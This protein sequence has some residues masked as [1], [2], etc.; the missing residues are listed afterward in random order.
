MSQTSEQERHPE[1]TTSFPLVPE[2]HGTGPWALREPPA[3]AG[4]QLHQRLVSLTGRL[5]CLKIVYP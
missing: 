1:A 5:V 4:K 3:T 2:T